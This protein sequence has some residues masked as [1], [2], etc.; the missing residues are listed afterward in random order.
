MK[1]KTQKVLSVILAGGMILT[2]M[3]SSCKP[4]DP[5]NN[6]QP[7]TSEPAGYEAE[8]LAYQSKPIPKISVY[9]DETA[10]GYAT[11]EEMNNDF[12]HEAK[13]TGTMD[14]DIPEGYYCDYTDKT[15]ETLHDIPLN[16]IRG[17]GNSTWGQADKKPYKIKLDEKLDLFGMGENKEWA[18]LASRYDAS[19][20]R[21]RC[22]FYLG[23][24]MGLAFTPQCVPVEFYMNDEYLGCYLLSETVDIGGSRVDIEELSPEDNEEPEIS[25]GY[26]F[27]LMCEEYLS[28]EPA[29]NA[30]K[31]DNGVIFVAKD[32]SFDPADGEISEEQK[33]YLK[34]YLQK[35]EDE[36][37]SN[38]QNIGQY[39]DLQSAADYWWI[40]EFV[41]NEDGFITTSSYLYKDRNGKLYFGPLWDFDSSWDYFFYEPRSTEGFNFTSMPWIDYMRANN[42]DFQRILKERYEVLDATLEE[43]V[44]DNGEIDR[45]AEENREAWEKDHEKWGYYDRIECD[46]IPDSDERASMTYDDIVGVYK[47]WI[48]E[49]RAWIRDHYDEI[50][51]VYCDVTF[52]TEDGEVFEELKNV[53]L[54][55]TVPNPPAYG[56][57]KEDYVFVDWQSKDSGAS[58]YDALITEDA[59]FVPVYIPA[60][61][62][63]PAEE[64]RFAV[65]SFSMPVG[66]EN[67]V[68]DYVTLPYDNQDRRMEWKSSDEEIAT[69]DE[70]GRITAVKE[71]NVEITAMLPGGASDVVSVHVYDPKDESIDLNLKLITQEKVTLKAGQ[72]MYLD[73]T[74]EDSNVK[75]ETCLIKYGGGSEDVATIDEN[76]LIT[77]IA[78]GETKFAVYG[79][80]GGATFER[81]IV[82]VTIN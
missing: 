40:Q 14:I 23:E 62:T 58:V 33:A 63:A 2:T 75:P 1:R 29:A 24:E 35:T 82:Q 52:E 21:N 15:P 37:M 80:R 12:F 77:A 18:L 39:L 51:N 13:C 25:G 43:M 41:Q 5:G 32:P 42:T 26:L 20:L 74:F 19:M 16:Y 54:D 64:I 70:Y 17:R 3:L 50:T 73:V 44:K 78:P 79:T 59:T 27:S 4:N 34:E 30:I 8:V 38:S 36:I 31:T 76:G 81:A 55:R 6:G 11:I 61:S 47:N 22:A 67:Y 66:M 72:Q 48:N 69:V 68:P 57:A 56:P 46:R 9:I 49:R 71:G 28:Q 65:R 45:L 53:R 60:D 7:A 10:E